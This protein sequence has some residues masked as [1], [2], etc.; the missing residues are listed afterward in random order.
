MQSIVEKGY[1]FGGSL[2]KAR[3]GKRRGRYLLLNPIHPFRNFPH[4]KE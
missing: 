2:I 3:L 1:L 4:D